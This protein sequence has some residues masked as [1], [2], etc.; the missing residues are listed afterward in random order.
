[1]I[2]NQK[3][4]CEDCNE[5]LGAQN[6]VSDGGMCHINRPNYLLVKVSVS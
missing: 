5:E 3:Q 2:K 4:V 6:G 1:M